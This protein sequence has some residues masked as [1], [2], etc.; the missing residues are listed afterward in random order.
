LLGVIETAWIDRAGET[1][2]GLAI[3]QFSRRRL[4]QDA[5]QDIQDGI[6]RAAS[7]GIAVD[8]AERD[9]HPDRFI[10]T[11]WQ[12]FEISLCPIGRDPHATP[13]TGL[14]MVDLANLTEAKCAERAAIARARRL[15]ALCET[16]WLLWVGR[17]T[18]ELAAEFSVDRAMIEDAL[19]LR[20]RQQIKRL[21]G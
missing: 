10:A 6:L 7:V 17:T 14:S 13:R 11:R 8:A 20:V 5:W 4:A 18:H 19:R 1:A 21:A 15:D 12:P 9:D 2:L 16:E 3:A